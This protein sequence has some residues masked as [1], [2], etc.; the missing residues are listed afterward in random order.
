ME[1]LGEFDLLISKTLHKTG[2][3]SL[4]FELCLSLGARF[5][6]LR[7]SLEDFD[8]DKKTFVENHELV[9]ELADTLNSLFKP[10]VFAVFAISSMQLC[11]LSFQIVMAESSLRKI[12]FSTFVLFTLIQLFAYAYG[13]QLI[14]DKSSSVADHVYSTDK[15]LFIIIART[16]KPVTIQAG[17]YNANLATFQA[18][19]SSAASLLTLLQ[20]LLK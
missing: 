4:F 11:V 17:I 2:V 10:I 7:S 3:D 15:D 18:I 9:L 19:M 5:D 1:I 6:D 16:Q 14:L 20:S 12:I 8:G 13:G